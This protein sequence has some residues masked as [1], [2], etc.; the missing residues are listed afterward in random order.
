[1]TLLCLKRVVSCYY[2]DQFLRVI[3][4]R[5]QQ[6]D[7]RMFGINNYYDQLF[8]IKNQLFVIL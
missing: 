2:S 1:M 6:S 7:I 8:D 5:N 3:N 4:T